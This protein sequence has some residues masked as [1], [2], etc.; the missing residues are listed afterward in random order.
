MKTEESQQDR[1][2]SDALPIG[3]FEVN[4]QG[5]CL[6]NNPT[7]Q[8]ILGRSDRQILEFESSSS[9]ME[10]W[11]DW[12]HPDD[13][14]F[15]EEKWK[16][17]QTTL[18][19]I[20][21]ECRL[22]PTRSENKWVYL[23]LHVIGTDSELRFLGT[24]EDI[25]ERKAAEESLRKANEDNEDIVSS[26]SAI[27][28]GIDKQ[29]RIRKWNKVAEETFG[30]SFSGVKGQPLQ[31]SGLKW[32]WEQVADA[33]KQCQETI[34]SIYLD[35]LTY[36][37]PDDTEGFVSLTLNPMVRDDTT[38][39][40]KG[41]LILGKDI[42]EKRLLER[43][44]L[45][46]QKLESI[47]QLAAGVA[48]EINT[49]IQF[50]G[51]NARFLDEAF[52]DLKLVIDACSNHTECHL[53]KDSGDPQAHALQQAMEDADVTYLIEEIP[54]ALTQSLE[55]IERVT[56][57]VRAMKEFSHPG[58]EGKT[59]IDLNNAI[60]STITISQNEWKYIAEVRTDYD[61]KLP[62][63]SCHAGELNQVI[64]NLIIN[65]THAIGDV[66]G[67]NS[68]AKGTITIQ[69]CNLPEWIQVRISD[70][71]AGIP[72]HVRNKIFDPFFTT[73]QV[74]KGTGQGL[75]IAHSV[76]VEKHKG[77]ITFET[78]LGKGT[79]F[80][81]QLPKSTDDAKIATEN[82]QHKV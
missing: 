59:T 48:H 12:F 52:A 39:A 2:F 29:S 14:P 50:L 79:T 9:E 35:N 36:Q 81:I 61:S 15:L 65:A 77:T 40:I 69:T 56:A 47:G 60:N 64:L 22:T 37:R 75:S 68:T 6:Y 42:T 33:I 19:R 1:T 18:Q 76:I 4:R 72:E 10:I 16:Q 21:M 7:F 66:L 51:D 63:V 70:T 20:T 30:L 54:R 49:P 38:K 45:Q 53:Q 58:V 17:F 27:M 74:G 57:I 67:P 41:I 80:I 28:I 44:L 24:L 23:C 55:G 32:E 26:I 31:L 78:E 43:Q 8:T 73:K 46:A 62:M 82:L 13:K 25:S 3:A 11:L 5:E 34:S 71:G